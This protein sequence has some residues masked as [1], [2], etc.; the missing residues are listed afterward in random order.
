MDGLWDLLYWLAYSTG[1]TVY[2]SQRLRNAPKTNQDSL[3][4]LFSQG[5]MQLATTIRVR[6][7]YSMTIHDLCVEHNSESRKESSR[8][9][10]VVSMP[11]HRNY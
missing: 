9:L 5:P 10:S 8:V 11:Q 1:S 2:Y 7:V 6:H 3:R 4:R